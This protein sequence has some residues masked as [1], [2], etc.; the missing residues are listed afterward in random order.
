DSGRVWLTISVQLGFVAGALCSAF[1][2]WADRYSGRALIVTGAVVVATVNLSI[3]WLGSVG[4]V[5]LARLLTGFCLAIV[6]PPAMKLTST[7]FLTRRGLA[8]GTLIA[9]ITVGSA[10][11]HL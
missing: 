1:F 11:P 2:G 9:A 6:Y 4:P 8:L 10:T 3:L 7:W 5:I